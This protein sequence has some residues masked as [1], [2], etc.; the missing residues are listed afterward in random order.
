[1]GNLEQGSAKSSFRPASKSQQVRCS[2][3]LSRTAAHAWFPNSSMVMW[4][5]GVADETQARSVVD[6]ATSVELLKK[7]EAQRLQLAEVDLA[8]EDSIA[9]AL[10]TCGMSILN[11]KNWL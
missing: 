2:E 4:R 6:F 3:S 8:D 1:M 10:P 7:Q 9:A 11:C 5:I